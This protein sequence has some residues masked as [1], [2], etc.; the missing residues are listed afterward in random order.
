MQVLVKQI[1]IVGR[2]G[3][4]NKAG[5][6][7]LVNKTKLRNALFIVHIIAK[8]IFRVILLV[9]K[10]KGYYK[11]DCGIHMINHLL[12]REHMSLKNFQK[13]V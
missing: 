2:H 10:Q 5:C 6:D 4:Y 1:Y 13:T 9:V 7:N 8:G 12:H 3:Q 11:S